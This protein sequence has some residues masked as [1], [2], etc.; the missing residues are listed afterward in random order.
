MHEI[1][2]AKLLDINENQ[3]LEW[4]PRNHLIFQYKSLMEELNLLY[5]NYEE[6]KQL[7]PNGRCDEVLYE[8]VPPSQYVLAD[9]T[10]LTRS[11]GIFNLNERAAHDFD[12]LSQ[13]TNATSIATNILPDSPVF[14]QTIDSI[15]TTLND[16]TELSGQKTATVTSLWPPI[17]NF[18]MEDV[19]SLL[20]R[21]LNDPMLNI[22]K[23][24][25]K[26]LID[27]L[28]NKMLPLTDL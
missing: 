16:G 19:P 7:Y 1:S 6:L 13:S 12:Q 2:G 25:I 21:T 23:S 17:F 20:L 27:I 5:P 4:F 15:K 8:L 9:R 26:D 18:P 22:R 10:N 24:E 3:K 14:K 11:P 28:F